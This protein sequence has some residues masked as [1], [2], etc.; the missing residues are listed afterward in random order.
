MPKNFRVKFD[1]GHWSDF[2]DFHK[3]IKLNEIFFN[4]NAFNTNLKIL[5]HFTA[6]LVFSEI[7]IC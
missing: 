3:W 5:T 4:G 6:K 7:K 1:C 2:S